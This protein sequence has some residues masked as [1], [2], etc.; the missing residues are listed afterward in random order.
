[1]QPGV[2]IDLLD[3]ATERRALR[4]G[5]ISAEDCARGKGSA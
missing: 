2:Y 5:M 3:P 4:P 1:M